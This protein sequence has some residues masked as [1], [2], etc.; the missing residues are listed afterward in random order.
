MALYLDPTDAFPSLFVF[1][2]DFMT[3]CVFQPEGWM[4]DGVRHGGQQMLDAALSNN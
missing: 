4:G 3:M 2:C 1:S